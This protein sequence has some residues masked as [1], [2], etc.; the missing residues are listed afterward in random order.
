MNVGI[1]PEAR[2]DL[3]LIAEWIA[4]DNPSRADSFVYELEDRC[5]SLSEFPERF[6]AIAGM[7]KGTVRKLTH[8]GYLIFYR[9]DT[10]S[11]EVLR[12]IHGARDWASLFDLP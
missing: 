12:I 1:S 5:Q 11:V 10:K 6:P 4:E 7:P 2:D 8:A 3:L 9:V